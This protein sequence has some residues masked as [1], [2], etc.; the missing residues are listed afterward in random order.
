ME[1]TKVIADFHRFMVRNLG[2]VTA[3]ETNCDGARPLPA[4]PCGIWKAWA[5][6][7]VAR[8]RARRGQLC[9]QLRGGR[10]ANVLD[11]TRTRR[12]TLRQRSSACPRLRVAI[13]S[14]KTASNTVAALAFGGVNV[15]AEHRLPL[16]AWAVGLAL[17]RHPNAGRAMAEA[18]HESSSDS[19]RWIDYS[20]VS[21]EQERADI[22][23][24]VAIIQEHRIAAALAGTPGAIARIR[25][26][27]SWRRRRP[28]DFD[29]YDDLPISAG[30]RQ[31]AL[32]RAVRAGHR[33]LQ[34]RDRSGWDVGE[35][36][37]GYLKLA[38]DRLYREGEDSEEDDVDRPST[39]G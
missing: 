2:E 27:S 33:R 35:D 32:D 28:Y 16:T 8:K 38:F 1:T 31:A 10:R 9:P 23:A 22:R 11:E 13:P 20:G 39:P 15:F 7:G 3:T 5:L 14:L 26:G 6:R 25:D 29:A 36:F 17:K 18:G 21:E 19:W 12:P 34:V 30:R 37:L 4:R 24:T